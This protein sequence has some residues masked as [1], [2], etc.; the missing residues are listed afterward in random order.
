MAE[1]SATLL[2]RLNDRS[3]SVAWKR[4]VDLYT[5]LI[6]SWLLRQGVSTE[7]AEDLAQEVLGIVVREVPRFQH[8]GRAGAFRTWLRTIT[9]NCIRQSWRARSVRPHTTR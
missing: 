6:N 8:N 3:D 4:L 1:T 5:P 7:D 9:S 2:Q